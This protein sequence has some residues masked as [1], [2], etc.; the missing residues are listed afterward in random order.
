MK[1]QLSEETVR[2]LLNLKTWQADHVSGLN[3]WKAVIEHEINDWKKHIEGEL[4]TALEKQNAELA[5][6]KAAVATIGQAVSDGF[7]IITAK[8]AAVATQ[9]KEAITPAQMDAAQIEFDA[10]QASAAAIAKSIKDQADALGAPAA[11]PA[12]TPAEPAPAA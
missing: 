12:A 5:E 8:Y 3:A 4:M 2:A 7:T 11:P 10:V 1:F 6:T 9:L